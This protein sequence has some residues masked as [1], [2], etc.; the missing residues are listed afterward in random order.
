MKV[1]RKPHA[2]KTSVSWPSRQRPANRWAAW[3]QMLCERHGR[4]PIRSRAPAR[5]LVGNRAVNLRQVE[6]RYFAS[7][8]FRW[9]IQL[10]IAP[11]LRCVNR[12]N[13]SLFTASTLK[14]YATLGHS[15][16]QKTIKRDRHSHELHRTNSYPITGSSIDLKGAGAQTVPAFNYNN[17]TI[18]RLKRNPEHRAKQTQRD[19]YSI[20]TPGASV[21]EIVQELT[22]DHYS[23]AFVRIFNRFL[24]NGEPGST[25]RRLET[26]ASRPAGQ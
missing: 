22:N 10:A 13:R 3:A 8:N 21:Q 26:L 16:M 14:E 20:A 18:S 15:F 4:M 1:M 7:A 17:L 6:R 5:L 9:Q 19:F 2:I 11:I 25:E 23:S 24:V 12:E